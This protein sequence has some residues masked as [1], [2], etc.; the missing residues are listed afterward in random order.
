MS[1]IPD[2]TEAL[3]RTLVRSIN[4]KVHHHLTAPADDESRIIVS[5]SLRDRTSTVNLKLDD[6]AAAEQNLM[7]RNRVRAAIKRGI[8]KMTFRAIPIAS[9]AMLRPDTQSAGFFRPPSFGRR[10]R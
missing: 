4:K 2:S 8:D 3:V 5:V 9:T 7:R 10:G 6:L 1:S